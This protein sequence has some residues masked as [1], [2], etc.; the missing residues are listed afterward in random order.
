M[1]VHLYHWNFF[2]VIKQNAVTFTFSEI[3][4]Y[5]YKVQG[6]VT[7]IRQMGAN[8]HILAVTKDTVTYLLIIKVPADKS[9]VDILCHKS[10]IRQHE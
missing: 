4:L 8:C 5:L 7:L 2:L 10:M 1:C 3:L 9:D 6:Q